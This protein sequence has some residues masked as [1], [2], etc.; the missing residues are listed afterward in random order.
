MHFTIYH[1]PFLTPLHFWTVRH[2][3]P[4]TL[5]FSSLK[6]TF[7]T[8]FLK[9]RD[10]QQKVASLCIQLC[11]QFDCPIYKAVFTD[12]CSSFSGPKFVIVTIPA[13]VA[14]SLCMSPIHFHALSPMYALNTAHM[15]A[16]CL[17]YAK[18]SHPETF[19]SFAN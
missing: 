3:P 6:I 1:C 16:I 11:P 8:L 17:R 10:L 18:V 5:H 13:Q 7:L 9:T 15:S 19:V 14:W 12:V 2:H 4:K